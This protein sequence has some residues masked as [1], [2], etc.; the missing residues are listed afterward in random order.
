MWATGASFMSQRFEVDG[1][2]ISARIARDQGYVAIS[3]SKGGICVFLKVSRSFSTMVEGV[4]VADHGVYSS[5]LLRFSGVSTKPGRFKVEEETS[6][7]TEF[8]WVPTSWTVYEPDGWAVYP[9]TVKSV[10]VT[11]TDP[12]GGYTQSWNCG[13]LLDEVAMI[14]GGLYKKYGK[15]GSGAQMTTKASDGG[16]IPAGNHWDVMTGSSTGY[17]QESYTINIRVGGAVMTEIFTSETTGSNY[18]IYVSAP[19][20]TPTGVS[21]FTRSH[22]Y[23]PKI[24]MVART[25]FIA[26]KITDEANTASSYFITDPDVTTGSTTVTPS[27]IQGVKDGSW[28]VADYTGTDPWLQYAYNRSGDPS[29][30]QGVSYLAT[31][32]WLGSSPSVQAFYSGPLT[33]TAKFSRQQVRIGG[34]GFPKRT[35]DAY[36]DQTRQGVDFIQLS[37]RF[38]AGA[39]SVAYNRV[40]DRYLNTMPAG[41]T[42]E[43]IIVSPSCGMSIPNTAVALTRYSYLQ[44]YDPVSTSAVNPRYIRYVEILGEDHIVKQQI[45]L[46]DILAVSTNAA[47]TFAIDGLGAGGTYNPAQTEAGHVQLT[48]NSAEMGAVVLDAYL[49]VDEDALMNPTS[50]WYTPELDGVYPPV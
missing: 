50:V 12:H 47:M 15:Q 45:D 3:G 22:V 14:P 20:G 30:Y 32:T 17:G 49:M 24:H 42:R 48:R 21:T 2:Q 43:N 19:A 8:A 38:T 44:F 6:G 4:S 31:P 41:M 35:G 10:A 46:Y 37:E 18:N 11:A 39:T 26:S 7:T 36:N 27:F 29:T 9:T 5:L 25:S 16:Y 28:I 13:L 23:Y 34:T 1:V 33:P 40:F